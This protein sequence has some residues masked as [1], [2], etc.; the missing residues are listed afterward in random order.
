MARSSSCLLLI[1]I[2]PRRRRWIM[3]ARGWRLCRLEMVMHH[4]FYFR[5][6]EPDTLWQVDVDDTFTCCSTCADSRTNEFTMQHIRLHNSSC[7]SDTYIAYFGEEVFWRKRRVDSFEILIDININLF[8]ECIITR[9][10]IYFL[11]ALLGNVVII[12]PLII[13]HPEIYG[14]L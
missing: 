8:F 3:F 11:L 5:Y 13:L 6:R 9:I 12:I 14:I 4:N 2:I 1:G 10:F 7:V